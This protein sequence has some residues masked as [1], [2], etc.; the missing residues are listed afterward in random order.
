VKAIAACVLACAT[1]LVSACGHMAATP[2]ETHA[3]PGRA[4]PTRKTVSKRTPHYQR[5]TF[6]D[7]AAEPA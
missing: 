3:S 7:L 5:G 1:L 2:R 6:H 4:E